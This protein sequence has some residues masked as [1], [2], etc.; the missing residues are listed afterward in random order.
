MI[1]EITISKAY[2]RKNGYS[3]LATATAKGFGWYAPEMRTN[4][5]KSENEAKEL[6]EKMLGNHEY[7]YKET[8][9]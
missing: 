4:F 5:T 1:F 7:T 2:D 3:Y 8:E 6:I 9:K